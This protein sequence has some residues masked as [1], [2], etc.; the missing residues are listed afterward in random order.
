[1]YTQHCVYVYYCDIAKLA[2][3]LAQMVKRATLKRV[4]AGSIP[5]NDI[6]CIYHCIDVHYM[7]VVVTV[8][9]KNESVLS[10]VAGLEPA[11]FRSGNGCLH[12]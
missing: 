1:M 4:V 6:A 9:I 5:G 8:V 3:N 10:S 2:Q 12:H 7:Y 11:I